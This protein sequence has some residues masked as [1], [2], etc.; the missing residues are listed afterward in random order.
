MHRVSVHTLFIDRPD[1][2]LI[3][4]FN[5]NYIIWTCITTCVTCIFWYSSLSRLHPQ[6]LVP[7]WVGADEYTC[8]NYSDEDDENQG[9]HILHTPD[10]LHN[11]NDSFR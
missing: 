5:C 7:Q 2:L 1:S 9:L 3:Y 10:H 11:R 4:M 6:S 8:P